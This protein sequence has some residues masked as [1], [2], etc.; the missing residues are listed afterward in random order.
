VPPPLRRLLL[1]LAAGLLVAAGPAGAQ[2]RPGAFRSRQFRSTTTYVA[3]T[4]PVSAYDHATGLAVVT[5]PRAV[6][7]RVYADRPWVLTVRAE[8]AQAANR[9]GLDAKPAS[10]LAVRASGEPGFLP[11]STTPTRVLSG[12]QTNG[13]IDVALDLQLTARMTDASGSYHFG[14]LLDFN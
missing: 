5:V 6:F 11:L 7:G 10:D 4:V 1:A 2:Y 9:S 3:I 13:W 14:L 8:S 12:V